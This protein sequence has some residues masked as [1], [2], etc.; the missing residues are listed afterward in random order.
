MS[1]TYYLINKKE[2]E[3]MKVFNDRILKTINDLMKEINDETILPEVNSKNFEDYKEFIIKKIKELKNLLQDNLQ[4]EFCLI[5]SSKKFYS[6]Y[7]GNITL[8]ILDAINFIKNNEDFFIMDECDELYSKEEF[9]KILENCERER[10]SEIKK[11]IDQMSHIEM[12]KLYR[13][14]S[15]DCEYFKKGEV[16]DYFEAKFKKYGGMTTAISKTIGW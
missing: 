4:T 7:K 13:F 6:N 9:L 12:A 14:G 1:N 15:S 10:I 11:K 5:T 8:T 3:K 2:N 16:G